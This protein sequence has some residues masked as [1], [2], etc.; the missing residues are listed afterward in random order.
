MQYTI[1][2]ATSIDLDFLDLIHTEN[3]KGYGSKN[4]S[5]NPQ[6]FRN[7]FIPDEYQV[8]EINNLIVGFM[9]IVSSETEIYLGEIQISKDFQNQGIGTFLIQLII[10]EVRADNKKLWL[11]VLKGNPA[12][13]L[14]QRLGFTKLKESS[15]HEIMVIQS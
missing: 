12:K 5:W 6:Q 3:R 10:Q 13:K 9:K 14:Y 15:T 8:I 1:R 4:Y 2:K 11:K 7:K